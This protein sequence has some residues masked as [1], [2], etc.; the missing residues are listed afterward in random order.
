MQAKVHS[1]VAMIPQLSSKHLDI[2]WN[3]WYSIIF[4]LST[5][6]IYKNNNEFQWILVVSKEFLESQI[7][8]GGQLV[9]AILDFGFQI[10]LNIPSWLSSRKC[11]FRCSFPKK[12]HFIIWNWW[13]S[14]KL[15]GFSHYSKCHQF[16]VEWNWIFRNC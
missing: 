8:H 4:Q 12:L 11:L 15:L 16:W 13:K 7:Q 14:L 10:I 3:P 2:H 1:K 5:M 6:G 9:V